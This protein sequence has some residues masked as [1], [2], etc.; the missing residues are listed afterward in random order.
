MITTEKELYAISDMYRELKAF[1]HPLGCQNMAD[2][3]CDCEIDKILLRVKR[4]IEKSAV[5]LGLIQR[6]TQHIKRGKRL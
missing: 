4:V 1:G 5:S 6:T 3:V 2:G